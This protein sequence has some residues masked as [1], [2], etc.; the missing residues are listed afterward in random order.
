MTSEN[1]EHGEQND[2]S[3]FELTEENRSVGAAASI[4]I[5]ARSTGR[6]TDDLDTHHFA[7]YNEWVKQHPNETG[8]SLRVHLP[9]TFTK[10]LS[11]IDSVTE[12][13]LTAYKQKTGLN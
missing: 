6:R 2:D 9:G 12:Q 5:F 8:L 10:L 3:G 4:V 13:Q 7:E 1:T 11:H